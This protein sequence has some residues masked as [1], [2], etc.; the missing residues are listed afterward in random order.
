MEQRGPQPRRTTI[1]VA[2]STVP[3]VA[4]DNF[5]LVRYAT[6]GPLARLTLNRPEHNLLNEAM[7]RE[8]TSGIEW[9]GDDEAVKLILID[10]ACK[11]F[12]GGIDVGEYST[13]RVFQ[14]TD[15]FH[16]VFLAMVDVGKPVMVVV[17]GPAIGGGSELAAFGDIVIATP[18]ARFAQPEITLGVFP[19]LA[20]TIFPQIVGPRLAMELVLIGEPIT[21][22]RARDLGLVSRLVP[23]A[24]LEKTVNAMIAKITAQSGAVLRMAKKAI[25]GGVGLSLQ[26]GLKTSMDI[27][28]NEL[29]KL[30]DSQ[31]GVRA[32]V[33]KR[34]PQWK[35]R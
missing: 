30:E 23:E 33:E 28:L 17:D 2:I 8:L 29:Y 35:N 34:K 19:P 24:E 12:S 32:L 11:T 4:K 31:E 7:L 14:M 3:R 13:Q 15:A 27:F 5:H 10:S 16:R 20:A 6:D 22:E 21:A 9:A 25:I 26:E 1:D 18:R